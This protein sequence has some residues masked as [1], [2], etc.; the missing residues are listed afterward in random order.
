MSKWTSAIEGIEDLVVTEWSQGLAGL[1]GDDIKRGLDNLSESWPPSVV[2]FRALCEG[3]QANGLGLD[4]KPPY[5]TER[6]R[7]RILESDAAKERRRKSYSVGMGDIKA[8]L[9]K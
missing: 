5:H 2:D 4:F 3:R 8:M 1:S 6:K 7:E 9:K